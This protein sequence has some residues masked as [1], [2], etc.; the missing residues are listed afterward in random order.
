MCESTVYARLIKK[1]LWS[2]MLCVYVCVLGGGGLG[3]DCVRR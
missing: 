1:C 3:M 2:Y